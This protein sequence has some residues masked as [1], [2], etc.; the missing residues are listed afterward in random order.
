MLLCVQKCVLHLYFSKRILT[1]RWRRC[2]PLYARSARPLALKADRIRNSRGPFFEVLHRAHLET[3]LLNN[4]S[5]NAGIRYPESGVA[6]TALRCAFAAA[7]Y[8]MTT[9]WMLRVICY[10]YSRWRGDGG[11]LRYYYILINII[12]P[13]A[14]KIKVKENEL[15][16]QAWNNSDYFFFSK[17]RRK[18][19]LRGIIK[20]FITY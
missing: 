9:T 10:S 4:I 7:K 16:V 17:Y 8:L 13:I 12:S 20:L 18:S 11:I 14:A 6:Y 15:I 3:R 5:A 2:F 1:Q 19:L